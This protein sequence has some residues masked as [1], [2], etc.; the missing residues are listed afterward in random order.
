MYIVA[1]NRER[2][3][4][5][6]NAASISLERNRIRVATQPEDI[7]I[8]MYS[9]DE[10]AKEVFTEMLGSMFIPNMILVNGCVDGDEL[11]K[12]FRDDTNKPW[13]VSITG[14]DASITP[15]TREIYYMP[16]E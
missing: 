16:E 2:V 9:S 13:G 11:A 10:R 8:G 5:I 14:V 3:V 4:N 15:V 12:K 6:S 7:L 1:W